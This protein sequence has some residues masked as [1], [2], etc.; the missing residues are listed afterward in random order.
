[1]GKKVGIPKECLTDL[2]PGGRFVAYVPG[3]PIETIDDVWTAV[4]LDGGVFVAHSIAPVAPTEFGALPFR[5][6]VTYV[7]RGEI[8]AAVLRKYIVDDDGDAVLLD[9]DEEWED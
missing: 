3:E 2:G 9:K 5:S 6:V 8:R 1:M 7:E 4:M